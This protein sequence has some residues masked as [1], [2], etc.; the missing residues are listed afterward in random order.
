[1]RKAGALLAR[2]VTAVALLARDP[3]VPRPLRALAAIG[4][5]PM[6][7]P[8]DEVVLL[9]VAPIFLI[10]YRDPMRD[11]WARAARA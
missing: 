4:L 2:T 9:L 10:F 5:V 8:L 7:G 1:M 11:A 3:R 6:P